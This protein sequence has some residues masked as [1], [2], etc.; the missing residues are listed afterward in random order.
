MILGE[1]EN[2]DASVLPMPFDVRDVVLVAAYYDPDAKYP[3]LRYQ[4]NGPIICDKERNFIAVKFL[5]KC[6]G[7]DIDNKDGAGVIFFYQVSELKNF[8]V[9]FMRHN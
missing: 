2:S 6:G 9:S 4:D 8:C 7:K 3:G 1:R 5:A